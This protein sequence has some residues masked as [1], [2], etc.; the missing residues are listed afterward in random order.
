MEGNRD[1]IFDALFPRFCVNC[2]EEGTLL[3]LR[4]AGDVRI[5]TTPMAYADPVVRKL[6]CSWKYSGD[7]E[8]LMRLIGL[9][10]PRLDSLKAVIRA[11]RIEAI[12]PVPLSSWKER[13]RGFNQARDGA[14]AMGELLQLPVTEVLLRRQRFGAQANLSH[15]ARKVSFKKSPFLLKKNAEVPVRVL[16][17]DDVETTGATMDAAEMVLRDAGVEEVVRW[18]FARG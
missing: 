17:F 5:D 13:M 12:V 1:V 4:C 9:L 2:D 8:G 16:L 14:R 6:I 7:Q 11:H 10:R 18:S 3:C 15:E